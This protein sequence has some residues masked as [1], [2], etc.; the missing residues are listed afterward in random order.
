M[1][2]TTKYVSKVKKALLHLSYCLKCKYVINT[3]EELLSIPVILKSHFHI[4]MFLLS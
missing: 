3:N 4:Q 2:L 1:L